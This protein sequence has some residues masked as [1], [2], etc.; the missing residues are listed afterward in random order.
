M[1]Y[2]CDIVE[3]MVERSQPSEQEGGD[4]GRAAAAEAP[5]GMN[6][7]FTGEDNFIKLTKDEII[8]NTFLL[9][10]A[11][12]ETTANTLAMAVYLLSKNKDKETK[13]IAEI[14]RLKGTQMPGQDELKAYEY[15][16]AVVKEALR[17]HGPVNSTDRH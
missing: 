11:G 15:V 6:L 14:D 13:L 2:L 4:A 10:L 9:I 12:Y 1:D 17:L 8:G 7:E 16:E 5:A 3:T